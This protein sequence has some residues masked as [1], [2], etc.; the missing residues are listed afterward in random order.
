[1]VNQ[2]TDPATAKKLPAALLPS[3]RT[4]LFSGIHLIMLIGLGLVVA[5]LLIN[6]QRPAPRPEK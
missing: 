4:I 1:M 2:L 5:A 6:W 3:L